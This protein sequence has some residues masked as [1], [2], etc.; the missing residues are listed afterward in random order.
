MLLLLPPSEGKVTPSSGGQLDLAK[1]SFGELTTARRETIRELTK[2]S[3]GAPA[4]AL[5]ILGLSARQ[6]SELAA[7]SAI[8][9]APIAPAREVYSGVLYTALELTNLAEKDLG[10]ASERILIASSLFGFVRAD[11]AIPA[12]RLSGSVTLPRIGKVSTHWRKALSR[13]T[14]PVLGHELIVDFRSGTYVSFWPIPKDREASSL[15]VKIWQR[16]AS[17]AKTAV[18][19]HNKAA[20]GKL[21]R[22][23]ATAHADLQSPAEV[24]EY[25]RRCD[26]DVSLEPDS[27]LGHPRLDVLI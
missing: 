7:N 13:S 6:V 3:S 12:Y 10:R 16:G 24:A 9:S 18:S 22:A 4:E 26:W 1:L 17:G 2:L 25:C 27:T 21:A 5:R 23:L 15:T 11:D 8:E 19:H 14:A 20:K